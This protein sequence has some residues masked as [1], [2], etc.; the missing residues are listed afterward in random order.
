MDR[1]SNA[2]SF[3]PK[4]ISEIIENIDKDFLERITEIRIR[5]D[6]PIQIRCKGKAYFADDNSNLLYKYNCHLP[7]VT[8][9]EIED[10]FIRLCEYSV[11]S[12][13]EDIKKGFITFKGGCRVGF[14]ATAV[15][16]EERIVSVKNISSFN[17][18]IA[19][20]FL[21]CSDSV[22]A[23][24]KEHGLGNILFAGEPS[25]GKTTILRDFARNLSEDYLNVCV[26]DERLELFD[27]TEYF[28]TGH[29]MDIY[30]SYPKHIAVSNAIR[31]MSPDFIVT[32]EIG[33]EKE[34][35]AIVDG[36]N[37]GVNFA[38]SI[39]CKNFEELKTKRIFK[40]IEEVKKFDYIVFLKN[41]CN[42][43]QI[44]EILTKDKR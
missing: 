21:G 40:M 35:R 6:S 33:D 39:H 22:Y 19:R 12:H 25:S 38:M 41:K 4:R 23:T 43:G 37:C 5:K 14:C 36:I 44:D 31:T 42:A 26:V 28:E 32:D 18:R 10:S 30:S 9:Q 34:C 15:R 16:D 1:I 2:I 17:I 29:C 11:Y 3:L 24:I 7:T 20:Q 13:L 8:K 27:N